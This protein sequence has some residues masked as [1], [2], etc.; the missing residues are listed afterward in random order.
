M[1]DLAQPFNESTP[2]RL[3]IQLQFMFLSLLPLDRIPMPVLSD[4]AIVTGSQKDLYGANIGFDAGSRGHVLNHHWI[5]VHALRPTEGE[6]LITLLTV[7]SISQN[8][9]AS[10]FIGNIPA[11]ASRGRR[12][13]KLKIKMQVLNVD[14]VEKALIVVVA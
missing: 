1:K 4:Y 6:V 11:V 5:R 13:E 8:W 12:T 2:L 10:G 3:Q 9:R 7:A 14:F